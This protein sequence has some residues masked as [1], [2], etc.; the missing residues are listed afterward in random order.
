MKC[1]RAVQ[2]LWERWT[3]DGIPGRESSGWPSFQLIRIDGIVSRWLLFREEEE[4]RRLILFRL[5]SCEISEAI[6]L[7]HAH[8][9]YRFGT[10]TTP[11]LASVQ[12]LVDSAISYLTCAWASSQARPLLLTGAKGSGKTSVAQR[13]AHL[14]GCNRD[15]MAGWYF[16]QSHILVTND[17]NRDDL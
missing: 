17:I 10:K 16:L 9:C 1:Q 7:C 3:I 8:I 14:T 5:S 15:V 13:I 2:S 12:C 11:A 4:T 6:R